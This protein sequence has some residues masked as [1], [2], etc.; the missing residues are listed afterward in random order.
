MMTED[1]HET[2]QDTLHSGRYHLLYINH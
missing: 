2:S 1:N